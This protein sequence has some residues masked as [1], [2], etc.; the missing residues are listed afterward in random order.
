MSSNSFAIAKSATAK[1]KMKMKMLL[2]GFP[3]A[4]LRNTAIQSCDRHSDRS[5]LLFRIADFVV[6]TLGVVD[7]SVSEFVLSPPREHLAFSGIVLMRRQ[8]LVAVEEVSGAHQHSNE[9]HN[10]RRVL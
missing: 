10:V 6:D 1:L 4:P 5:F 9:E 7:V 8:I 2:A 3:E